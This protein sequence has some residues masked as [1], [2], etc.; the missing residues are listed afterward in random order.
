[1]SAGMN[2]E[3]AGVRG[4]APLWEPGG[5]ERERACM[6][7]FMRWVGEREG[8]T[9]EGYEQLWEWSVREPE[10]FWAAVWEY[11]EVRCS[12]PYEQVLASREM[13]GARWFTGA[14]LNYAE[15]MLARHAERPRGDRHRARLRAAPPRRADVG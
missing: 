10:L 1:M 13:P 3:A 14:E 11:F 2:P 8:R 5:A 6:T 12:R 9:F 4:A 15:N 7:A